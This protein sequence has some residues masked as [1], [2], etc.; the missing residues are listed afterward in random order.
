MQ[1][2]QSKCE[3]AQTRPVNQAPC[4]TYLAAMIVCQLLGIGFE[5]LKMLDRA[6]AL[7]MLQCLDDIR[8]DRDNLGPRAGSESHHVHQGLHRL[9]GA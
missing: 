5:P 7:A 3:L 9:N 6:C 4:A 2:N 8:V 1:A